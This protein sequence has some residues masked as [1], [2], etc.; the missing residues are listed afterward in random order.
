MVP[1]PWQYTGDLFV[2][3]VIN[4]KNMVSFDVKNWHITDLATKRVYSPDWVNLSMPMGLKNKEVANLILGF[5]LK[6][7]R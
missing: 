5:P 4:A 3:I 7:L 6:L 1:L 2:E